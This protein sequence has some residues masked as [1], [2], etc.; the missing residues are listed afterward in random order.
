MWTRSGDTYLERNFEAHRTMPWR[1]AHAVSL[2]RDPFSAD[3][4]SHLSV[5]LPRCSSTGIPSATWS[6]ACNSDIACILQSLM[7]VQTNMEADLLHC[8][9][10]K[11]NS[12]TH[13]ALQDSFTQCSSVRCGEIRSYLNSSDCKM[14]DA[15]PNA[16]ETVSRCTN[17][18]AP[19]SVSGA[20][21]GPATR[22][23]SSPLILKDIR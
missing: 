8:F 20:A 21:T 1:R 7:A 23:E 13:L 9:L 22:Y 10:S 6:L 4:P 18:I 3:Y 12:Y 2:V 11:S 16:N 19:A 14:A 5:P 15:A 17:R